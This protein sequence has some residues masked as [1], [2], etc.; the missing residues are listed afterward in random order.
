ML[1]EFHTNKKHLNLLSTCTKKTKQAYDKY[2]ERNWKNIKN[3]WKRN[4]KSVI[5]LRT[6]ASNVPTVLSLW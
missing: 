2:F 4:Y 3:T 5:S 1:E 6:V